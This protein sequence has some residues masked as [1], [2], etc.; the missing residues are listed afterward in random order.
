MQGAV[1]FS[2]LY[3]PNTTVSD[4]LAWCESIP[5]A[6]CINTSAGINLSARSYHPGGINVA[7]GDG[8]IR[9]I[10]DNIDPTTYQALGTRAGG[11]VFSQQ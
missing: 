8:S 10:T 4:R 3:P 1:I 5:K 11:E 2:T 6:P 9:F 7:F